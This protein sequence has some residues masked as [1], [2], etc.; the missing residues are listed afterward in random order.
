MASPA[1]PKESLHQMIDQMSTDE[2]QLLLDQLNNQRDPDV[3]SPDEEL[4]CEESLK[5]L[6]DGQ[7]DTLDEFRRK[8]RI[9]V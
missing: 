7:Y 5:E 1:S 3:L 4:E 9:D 8:V 2:A 6:A